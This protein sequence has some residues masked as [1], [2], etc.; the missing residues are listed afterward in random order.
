MAKIERCEEI[1]LGKRRKTELLRYIAQAKTT[2]LQEI[3]LFEITLEEPLS[4]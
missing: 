4:Q 3:V 1:R 2:T